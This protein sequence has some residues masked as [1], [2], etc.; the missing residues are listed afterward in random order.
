MIT[1]TEFFDHGISLVDA[2]FHRP[3]CAAC[4]IMESHG[5]VAIIETGTRYSVT[6][7]FDGLQERALKPDQVDYVIVTHVHLDHAGGAGALM[8]R[9][10]N[11]KLVVH[12]RGARH[13]I[14]PKK[15]TEGSIVVYGKEAFKATYGKITPIPESRIITADDEQE[16]VLGEDRVLKLLDTRGHAKHHLCIWDERSR[17]LF[18]GDSFG[19]SYREFDQGDH[20]L[21]YPATTPIQFEPDQAHSTLDRLHDLHPKWLYLTHF[22]RLPYRAELA[23]T[24]HRMLDQVERFALDHKNAHNRLEVLKDAFRTMMH[25]ELDRMNSTVSQ[26]MRTHVLEMDVTI[27]AQG[28]D[29]WLSYLE[30][31]GLLPDTTS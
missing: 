28:L 31:K 5:R 14:D 27:N 11:A 18:T 12:L 17:G 15:L 23:T 30:K 25:D 2:M 3:G 20:C 8:E 9:L 19:L 6:H 26:E 21:I 4:Y 13:M 10:P 29:V 16:I 24:L 22:G 1:H 7:I